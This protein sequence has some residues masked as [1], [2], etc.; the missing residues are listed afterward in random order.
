MVCTVFV[1]SGGVSNKKK[2]YPATWGKYFSNA[3]FVQ[4]QIALK[5]AVGQQGDYFE[6][7]FFALCVGNLKSFARAVPQIK[8]IVGRVFFQDH[9]HAGHAVRVLAKVL[10]Q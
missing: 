10:L 8:G 7:D 2:R 4:E 6:A 1:L 9:R 5:D 3:V